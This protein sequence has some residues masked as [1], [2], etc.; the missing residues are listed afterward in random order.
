MSFIDY[1]P[2][3][4]YPEAHIDAEMKLGTG[5]TCGTYSPNQQYICTRRV[6]LGSTLR[7]ATVHVAHVANGDACAIWDDSDPPGTSPVRNTHPYGRQAVAASNMQQPKPNPPTPLPPY[8]S[9]CGNPTPACTCPKPVAMPPPNG[10]PGS[11]RPPPQQAPIPP[12]GHTSAPGRSARAG[13]QMVGAVDDW[14]LIDDASPDEM[15][16]L[17]HMSQSGKLVG[18]D[19]AE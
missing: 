1:N 6:H 8:C 9:N 15:R 7:L 19:S 18:P 4:L 13:V 11:V 10:N 16:R 5:K 12:G 17:P 14:D 2:R 3:D